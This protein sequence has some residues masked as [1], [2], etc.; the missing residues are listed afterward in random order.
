MLS[1]V[2]WTAMVSG[3]FSSSRTFTPAS[4][5]TAAAPSAWAW[6]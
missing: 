2:F 4:L 1:I 3:T 6:L 5:A